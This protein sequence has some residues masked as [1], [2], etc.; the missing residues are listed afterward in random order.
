MN[1]VTRVKGGEHREEH[2]V[3]LTETKQRHGLSGVM[4]TSGWVLDKSTRQPRCAVVLL[5]L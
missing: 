3:D 2:S 4:M 5:R 1:T